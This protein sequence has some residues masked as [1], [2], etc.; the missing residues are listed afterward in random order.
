MK[1]FVKARLGKLTETSKEVGPMYTRFF[2]LSEP[3]FSLTP[4]PRYLYMS[5]KHREGLA[6]LIFGVQQPGGFIQLTG[7]IGC[8]KTTLCRCLVSQ[9]PAET[10]IALIL[11]PRMTV[12][13]LLAAICDELRIPYPAGTESVKVL[14][15]AINRYLLESHSRGRHTVL[16]IDEA[17]NLQ[18]DVLEQIRLLTNLETEKEKL[19]QI[20]LIGQPEL[21]KVL[22]DPS[23]RQLAQRITARYHLHPLSR[24]ETSSYIQ[25]RLFVAGLSNP[26][27]TQQALE[28]TFSLSGGVPRLINILCDRALLGAYA[29]DS[30]RVTGAIVR[31]AAKE[32]GSPHKRPTRRRFLYTCSIVAL[33]ALLAA[34]L[35]FFYPWSTQGTGEGIPE[36]GAAATEPQVDGAPDAAAL[37]ASVA[38]GQADAG[39]ISA[40]STANGLRPEKTGQVQANWDPRDSGTLKAARFEDLMTDPSYDNSLALSFN[41]LYSLWGVPIKMEPGEIGCTAGQSLGFECLFMAGDWIKIR[42]LDIPVILDLKSP[43]G[44]KRYVTLLG[45]RENRATVALGDQTQSFPVEDI[46]RFWDGSFI[47]IWK[48]PFDSLLLTRGMQGEE[49]AWVR[50]TLNAYEGKTEISSPSKLFDEELRERVVLF[51]RS[52]SLLPDGRVGPETLLRLSL[53]M[54]RT[55]IPLLSQYVPKEEV[56]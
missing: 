20:I 24:Q 51:Q 44:R 16:V 6:H 36:A 38:S 22:E 18:T 43:D 9:L 42:R 21:I 39:K 30:R 37:S 53:V 46:A 50:R 31:K 5:E 25:H 10:D 13:E 23:L 27:F 15:D 33:L 17:Q 41:S 28:E 29:L 47:L 7:E 45:L 14:I 55:P 4:D 49:V 2:R 11:N 48:P 1:S 54:Y 35:F 8:G 19:L 32:I 40:L 52:Q 12:L 3:P 34:T 26:V 56:S